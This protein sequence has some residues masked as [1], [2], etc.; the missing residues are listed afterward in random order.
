MGGRGQ[1]DGS[2]DVCKR[3]KGCANHCRK[4]GWYGGGEPDKGSSETAGKNM[5]KCWGIETEI[6]FESENAK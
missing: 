6:S 1:R 4:K 3:L 2:S 5:S